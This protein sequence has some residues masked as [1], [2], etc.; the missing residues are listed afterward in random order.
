MT[1]GWVAFCNGIEVARGATPN[2]SRYN[3]PRR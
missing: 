2:G 1:S 3:S